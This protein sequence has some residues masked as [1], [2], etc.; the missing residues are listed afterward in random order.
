M[1]NNAYI[2]SVLFAILFSCVSLTAQNAQLPAHDFTARQG[3]HRVRIVISIKSFDASKHQ[4]K[5]VKYRTMID[6]RR[7]WGTDV[8][9]PNKEITDFRVQFDRRWVPIPRRLYSDC[10]EPVFDNRNFRIRL[11]PDGRTARVA[12]HGSDAAGS[13]TVRWWFRK[14]GRHSRRISDDFTPLDR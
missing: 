10:F 2:P 6:G 1:S 3:A 7:A 4:M 8:S 5:E 9:T 12:M 14:T 13:Y 11:S